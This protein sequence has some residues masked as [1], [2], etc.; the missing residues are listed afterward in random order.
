VIAQTARAEAPHG[1]SRW[2]RRRCAAALT[3]AVTLGSLA[4]FVLND[5]ALNRVNPESG[6]AEQVT[7]EASAVA[8][9]FERKA[10]GDTNGAI[11]DWINAQG[12]TTCCDR[13]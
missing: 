12:F 10:A 1:R 5:L 11:A 3:H 13:S 9:A 6:I 4:F 8:G 7:A 2:F